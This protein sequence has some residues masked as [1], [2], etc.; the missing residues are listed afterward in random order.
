[1]VFGITCTAVGACAS[2]VLDGL[3]GVSQAILKITGYVMKPIFLAILCRMAATNIFVIWL[4]YAKFLVC[5]WAPGSPRWIAPG[6]TRTE[7]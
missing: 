4:K 6:V 5:P 7:P 2:V 3:E 1:M